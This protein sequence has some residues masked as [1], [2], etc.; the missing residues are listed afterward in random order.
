[1]GEKG[2]ETPIRPKEPDSDA[3]KDEFSEETSVV[4]ADD[5]MMQSSSKEKLGRA[6]N[7][8]QLNV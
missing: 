5:L 8:L 4:D 6:W 2:Q 1:M 7:G 3:V